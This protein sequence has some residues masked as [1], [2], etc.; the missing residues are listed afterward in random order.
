MLFF[1]KQD[2]FRKV[3]YDYV[4]GSAQM[5]KKNGVKQFHLISSAGADKNSY[6][7]YPKTKG[8]SEEAV[9]NLGFEKTAI[10]R[11]KL[12]LTDR[13]ESRLGEKI[14]IVLT[15]PIQLLAP[16]LISTPIETLAKSVIANTI[17]K[18]EEEKK[19]E[20]VEN[21]KIF[22]LAKIFDQINQQ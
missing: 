7:L 10:Y 20:I 11:P 9:S 19:V 21:C 18:H 8:E 1:L 2:G 15:K 22:E 4:V 17:F 6:F 13:N 3:D 12:L 14:A 5:A 16:T